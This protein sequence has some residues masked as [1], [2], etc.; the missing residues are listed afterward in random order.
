MIRYAQ[1]VVPIPLK[2]EFTYSFDSD[3][4]TVQ[5]GMRVMVPFGKRN[6]Q[7]YVIDVRTRLHQW[8]SRS[9]E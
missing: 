1:V 6:L 5:A 8:T 2:S 9:R 3:Q 4:M 7:A